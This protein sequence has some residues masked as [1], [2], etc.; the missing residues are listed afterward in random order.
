MNSS[1]SQV[2]HRLVRATA[3]AAVHVASIVLDTVLPR[4]QIIQR[5]EEMSAQE[6]LRVLPRAEMSE[7]IFQY[8]HP[9][10]RRLIWELKYR[11]NPRAAHLCGEVMYEKIHE[12][13]KATSARNSGAKS[14]P[15]LIPI[16]LS[17]ERWKERGFNQNELVVRE[18]L[19]R[20]ER[21]MHSLEHATAPTFNFE[22][23]ALEKV[24]HTRPQSSLTS[25]VDRLTNLAGCFA[26]ARPELIRDRDIIVIDDVATTGS[27]LA[28]ARD[29]LLR[30]GA[31]SVIA[32]VLAH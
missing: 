25:R 8:R 21:N 7:A 5:I 28:E 3:A 11:G 31:R 23:N 27:T 26:V 18:I 22:F 19:A 12:R 1:I 30:A 10:V 15:L 17:R 16:P 9:I 4:G 32:V 29:T 20:D 14:A 13:L 2:I 6:A 24:R